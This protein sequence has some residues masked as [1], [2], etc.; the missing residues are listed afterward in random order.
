MRSSVI[1]RPDAPH[2]NF[3]T[4]TVRAC[5]SAACASVRPA[6]AISGSVNTTAGI[7]RGANATFSPAITSTATRPSCDAL[8]ASIGSP[9]TSPIAKIDGSCGAALLVDHD[10]AAL[11]D[12][13]A[14]SARGRES[15]EFGRRPTADEHAIEQLL[16]SARALPSKR[17]ADA[18]RPRPSSATTC[19]SSSTLFI[20]CVDALGEDVDE[21]AIGAGQQARRHLDDGDRAAERG[22]DRAELE[23]DVAAADDEQRLRECRADRAP[24][25]S[26]SRADRRPSASA[27]SPAAI[28]SRG[29]RARTARVSSPP[30][31]SFTRSVC[32]STISAQ[33]W[34]Y[35]TLR[36]LASWPVPLVSRLTTSFLNAR[37]LSRSIFGSPNS[38]PHAFAWR[39][40]SISVGDVQQRLRRNA[41]AIDADAARVLLRDRRARR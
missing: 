26:P 38:T 39:D 36:C 28:R 2:G 9:T 12:L 4:V 14:A 40:S 32:A 27:E 24:R 19:V 13:H 31:V 41:A 6:H 34:R 3:A 30:A 11:V 7:A 23:A 20:V 16:A 29:S 22:V 5:L 15:L 25:S 37:S 18:L 17:D 35:W 10:E 21:I 1:A 33:P 8:C